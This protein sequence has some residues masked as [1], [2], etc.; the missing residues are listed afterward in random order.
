MT[1]PQLI[2]IDQVKTR[3]PRW[4]DFCEPT[5]E[6]TADEVL[7]TCILL[8]EAELMELVAIDADT[9]TE[10]LRR[11]LMVIIKKN[12]FDH[13]HGEQTFEDAKPQIIRDYERTLELLDRY[14]Q[15]AIMSPA[16]DEPHVTMTAKPRRF[17]Q[18]FL[19]ASTD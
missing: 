4:A 15:G 18:W 9:I 5:T 16:D 11:H 6:A 1:D 13:L 7:H 3:F 19:D 8:A 17:D 2:T 10:A 12:C 14:L